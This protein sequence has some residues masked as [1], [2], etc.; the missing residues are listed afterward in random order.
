MPGRVEEHP[1]RLARLVLVLARTER[2]DGRLGGIEI[3]DVEIEVHLLR[4]LG[5]RPL[6]RHVV[7]RELEGQRDAAYRASCTQSGSSRA[8]GTPRTA[9]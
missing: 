2:D 4:V 3:G 6:R 1:E 8:I 9:L 5:A 7:G